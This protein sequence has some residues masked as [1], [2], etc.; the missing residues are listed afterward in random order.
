M[1]KLILSLLAIGIVTL[2]FAQNDT[3]VT[4][5][6]A[7]KPKDV[8]SNDHFMIQLGALSWQGKPDSIRTAGVPRTFNI[9]VM[10]DFPFKTSPNWSVALGP[11]L[12]TDHMFLDAANVD[13]KSNGAAVHFQNLADTIHFK[14]YKVATAFAEVPVELRY[15][16]NSD[17]NANS[18][19][20]AVGAKVGTLLSSWTKG[21]NLETSGGNAYN[22]YIQKEKSKRFF[23]TTR[24]SLM[25][26]IGYG[27]FT[28]FASYS[29]TPLFKEG[30]GPEIKP[31]TIGITLSGL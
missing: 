25:G 1:R 31:M 7:T 14:K 5:V 3:T 13:L 10:L 27:H 26:R 24:L 6:T 22:N 23:N 11:G 17:R 19:K 9:Y 16:F 20:I 4:T 21:K 29:L 18:V 8:Q 12:A 28:A 15:A 30:M 2:S